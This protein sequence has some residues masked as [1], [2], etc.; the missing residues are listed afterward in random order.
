MTPQFR[1]KTV[2]LTHEGLVR[3][4]NEDAMLD[5]GEFGLW[6]VAD[7]MGG[8]ENGRWA[9]SSVVASLAG[10]ALQG[11]LAGDTDR[12]AGAIHAANEAIF[13]TAEA[14]G[15]RM[16]STVVAL[17]ICGQR[18]QCYWAGDSRIYL[19]RAG[20]LVQLTRDHTQVEEMVER[21]MLTRADA[22]RHP[23]SH[24][25]SR[26]IGVEPDLRLDALADTV[27]PR[28]IFLLCSDG[29]TGLVSDAEITERLAGFSPQTACNRLLELVLSRGGSDNVTLVAVLCEEATT[30]AAALET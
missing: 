21:G 7:G 23:M 2:A 5:R 19:L 17:H 15:K 26:A 3:S 11:E 24:V 10:V 20:Q 18:F 6:V 9:S 16:G 27:E 30:L 28:D 25:L 8:H 22:W 12:I 4:A 13:A 1:F 29:L 14:A